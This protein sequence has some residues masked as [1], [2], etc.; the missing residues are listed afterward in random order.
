MK[1]PERR[2]SF[3]PSRRLELLL[4]WF[5]YYSGL[6]GLARLWSQ[7]SG[8]TLSIL[9]YHNAAG[10]Y[11]REHLLYLRRHYRLLHLEAAL[12]E[13]YAPCKDK[14]WRE[15][16]RPLLALT[17][18]DGYHDFL[19]CAM[20][21][22]CELQ[23]PLTSFLIPGYIEDGKRFWWLEPESL[24]LHAQV[25]QATLQGCV[26]SLQ[27]PVERQKLRAA[28]EA[29]LRY[30]PSVAQRE[31]FLATVYATLAV[32]SSDELDGQAKALMPLNWAEV[33]EMEQSQWISFG[34]HTMHHP[35]LAYLTNP[36]ELTYEISESRALL[37]E[38][39]KRPIRSFA[40]PVGKDEHIGGSVKEAVKA[41]GYA[42]AVTTLHGLNTPH[43][44]PHFLA[45]I[46]VDVDQH[47]LMIA[48]K[49]SGLWD[50]L[51]HLGRIPVAFLR[52]MFK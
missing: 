7:R 8:P 23:I 33:R 49:T 1:L 13:L 43:T 19:T 30:A 25:E 37:E 26:Y 22:A 16:R 10:G 20:P 21:L 9:C 45:R 41:A 17:F 34:A 51:V 27:N 15:D 50:F 35:V 18:D 3:S 52:S 28:I 5:L 47:W 48:A 32:S 44:D 14:R 29:G 46:V 42:W 12:E 24:L 11:L 36:A 6:V 2:K 39:L 38:Q 31:T 40:Y 4:A